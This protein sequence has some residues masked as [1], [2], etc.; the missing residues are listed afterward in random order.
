MAMGRATKRIKQKL[1]EAGYNSS[2]RISWGGIIPY[3]NIRLKLP[4][5]QETIDREEMK[6]LLSHVFGKEYAEEKLPV[7]KD[8]FGF[9]PPASAF[10]DP[11]DLRA[12]KIYPHWHLQERVAEML[13]GW[14]EKKYYCNCGAIYE[15]DQKET[16]E[17]CRMLH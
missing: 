13:F 7:W 5:E 14:R 6:K 17:K 2:V 8:I 1:K 3:I 4:D 9:G 11:H 16:Y 15:L 12:G 10:N